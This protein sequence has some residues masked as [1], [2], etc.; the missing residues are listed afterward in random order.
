MEQPQN[1]EIAVWCH[2]CAAAR[3]AVRQD[4]SSTSGGGGRGEGEEPV[5]HCTTCGS[6]F[7]ERSEDHEDTADPSMTAPPPSPGPTPSMFRN[8]Q[9]PPNTNRDAEAIAPFMNFTLSLLNSMA[10]PQPAPSQPQGQAEGQGQGQSVGQG[11]PVVQNAQQ[12]Q[13]G[14]VPLGQNVQPGQGSVQWQPLQPGQPLNSA[15]ENMINSVLGV[16]GHGNGFFNMLT[17]LGGPQQQGGAMGDYVWGDGLE[18]V[19]NQMFQSARPQGIP[20]A[21]ESAI[22]QLTRC[23]INGQQVSEHKDCSI[24]QDE[25]VVDEEV[26]QLPCLHLFHPSCIER[27]LRMHNQCPVCRFSLPP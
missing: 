27:W 15:M 22:Q 1:D 6:E 16:N 10:N 14:Q 25:F 4:S 20:P 19:L 18:N 11:Q 24:C 17:A 3:N 23:N 13:F 21:S 5:L 8:A 7:V 26:V 12:G 9:Q 2:I